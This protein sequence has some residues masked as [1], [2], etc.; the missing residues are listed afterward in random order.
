MNIWDV[1]AGPRLKN[2]VLTGNTIK[3][4]LRSLEI[5]AKFIEKGLFYK[6]DLLP[7]LQRE[8]LRF[9]KDCQTTG[10]QFIGG[11]EIKPQQGR[12]TKHSLN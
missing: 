6:K 3:T 9:R 12:L 8:S 2:K 5:F 1:F 11:Q 7:D 4:F 10:Q